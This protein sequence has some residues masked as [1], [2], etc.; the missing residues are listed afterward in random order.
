MSTLPPP[1]YRHT[2][3]SRCLHPLKRFVACKGMMTPSNRGKVMQQ[4]C[5][6]LYLS[7]PLALTHPRSAAI[8]CASTP[9]FTQMHTPFLRTPKGWLSMPTCMHY[10]RLQ[11]PQF[12]APFRSHRLLSLS[13]QLHHHFQTRSPLHL[14]W[15]FYLHTRSLRS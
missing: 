3:C 13:L 1:F 2:T 8:M 14:M 5:T 7:M 15:A 11:D 9:Y 10:M 4:V 6:M 12:L